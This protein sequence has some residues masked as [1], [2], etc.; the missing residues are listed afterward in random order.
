MEYLYIATVFAGA[1]VCLLASVLLFLRRKAG[2][3][4]RII[5]AV[6][7]FFSV[8]NYITRFI[9]L[10]RGEVPEFI[11]SADMLLLANFMVISYIMYPVE[12]ISPG[13]LN[14]SR[15][16]GLYSVWLFFLLVYVITLVAGVN[17]TQY[18][19]VL[20]MLSDAG[21]FNVWFRLIMCA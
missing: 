12:V 5:L 3:R 16:I 4:S 1:L 2:G 18:A 6:I 14:L 8:L 19:S 15:I 9:D 13:W 21:N 11:V 17:Y 7:V 20:D 10:C